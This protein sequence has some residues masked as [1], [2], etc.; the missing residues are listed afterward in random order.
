M[1]SILLSIIL[2]C[3]LCINAYS[4]L[5][6]NYNYT[7]VARGYSLMQMPKVFE[8][9][10]QRYINGYLN[11][12]MIKFNDN[13]ISYRLSGNY[14]NQSMSFNDNCINCELAHG[15]VRDYAF[16]LGFEKSFNYSAVQPYF[17]F[18]AGYRY[19][20]FQG[21]LD[22]LNLQRSVVSVTHIESTK[23]G[24]TI[25]PVIGLKF[26]PIELITIFVESS[27]EFYYSYERRESVSQDASASR[28]FNRTYQGEYLLN[29]VSAG[30]QIHLS[31]KN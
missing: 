11:G 18:D 27:L 3:M 16:K 6:G 30:I 10:T 4:Q 31:A 21:S 20:R 7:I 28:T 23:N 24:F 1:K 13:Q 9:N 8:Q 15:I 25:A 17:A 14:L 12:G 19:N 5:N 2:S 22:A 26:N 29:P